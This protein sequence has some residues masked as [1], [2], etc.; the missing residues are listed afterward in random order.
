[1]WEVQLKLNCKVFMCKRCLEVDRRKSLLL[2]QALKLISFENV[3]ERKKT[4]T[5]IYRILKSS[6]KRMKMCLLNRLEN[7]SRMQ[8]NQIY[9][10][11]YL[12]RAAIEGIK[13]W[14]NPLIR[15]S[16]KHQIFL[17]NRRYPLEIQK[18]QEFEVLMNKVWPVQQHHSNLQR[19][20]LINM[21]IL[22]HSNMI[23]C[24][25]NFRNQKSEKRNPHSWSQTKVKRNLMLSCK[26]L[27]NRVFQNQNRKFKPL[28][29]LSSN[30]N[31]VIT[32]ET[33]FQN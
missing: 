32:H 4:G 19:R 29:S 26:W 3:K 31:K 14:Q 7:L 25:T 30:M 8:L 28:I 15:R 9:T 27:K 10:R 22:E 23:L 17:P 5:I 2:Y 11:K 6:L 18:D 21:K 12:V 33:Q 13:K 24:S 20:N 16:L 1:M